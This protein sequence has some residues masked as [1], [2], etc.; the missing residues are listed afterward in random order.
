MGMSEIN[1]IKSKFVTGV[2]DKI[3]TFGNEVKFVTTHEVRGF[4]AQ[5]VPKS[6]I[7]PSGTQRCTVRRPD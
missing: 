4:N 2:T 3:F 1:K 7:L 5:S 6:V